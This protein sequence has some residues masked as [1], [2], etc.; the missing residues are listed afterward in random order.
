MRSLSKAGVW[1]V[2]TV[3]AASLIF[4]LHTVHIQKRSVGS[5]LAEAAVALTHMWPD[6]IDDDY[7]RKMTRKNSREY[8]IPSGI[9]V[10]SF[11]DSHSTDGMKV[12]K[13]SPEAGGGEK[14]VLYLHGGG[15]INQPSLFHWWFLDRLVQDT[16]TDFFVPIYPK[17]PEYSYKAA[18][19]R[20]MTVYEDLLCKGYR[21]I[22][23]MGDS[24]GGG[25]ALGFSQMLRNEDLQQP[26][27]II[28]ISPW[29]DISLGH[30]DIRKYEKRD[31][32]LNVDNLRKIG[33]L[34]AG[35]SHPGSYRLSPIN[36]NLENLG[37][38]SIFI[39]THE[40]CFPDAA[41]LSRILNEQGIGHNYFEYNRMNHN[42]PLYPI[43]EGTSSRVQIAE[44]IR[45]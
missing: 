45:Q 13:M 23:L 19:T 35:G 15:Y 16:D 5:R 21:Q 44:L 3:G 10:D 11:L 12:Y 26:E 37:R 40:I 22:I 9:I 7:I 28:L 34:W 1:G 8:T 38:I 41:E 27:E 24:A 6:K 4:S 42:F 29:L 36:G 31:P 18:Y 30:E 32:M 43:K 2:L 25:M 17:A 33:R 20:L 14:C 39:G